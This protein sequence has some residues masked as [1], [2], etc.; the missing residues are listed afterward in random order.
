MKLTGTAVTK[1]AAYV[2]IAA[3]LALL[4]FPT[5][6]EYLQD[7]EQQ[8]ILQQL[9][10]SLSPVEPARSYDIQ[11]E[12]SRLSHVLDAGLEQTGTEEPE[13]SE[14]PEELMDE[15]TIGIIEIDKIELK[16]PILEGA[17]T[18]TM[19]VGA[20]HMT[21]TAPLGEIG[22]A[23]VAAHRARTKGRMFNRL[24]EVDIGD[25]IDIRTRNDSFV[26]QVTDIKVVLPTDLSVL[27]NDGDKAT[28]TLNTCDPLVNPTHRLIVRAER[29]EDQG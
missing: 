7:R 16:L 29:V 12:Y 15:R 24:N 3:G 1:I 19:K 14:T 26:Y 27:D 22:N 5:V 23:A 17:T 25:R 4:A 21:E 13:P 10:Q 20:G 8:R 6:R 28:L 2:L 18:Q 9:E 11:S